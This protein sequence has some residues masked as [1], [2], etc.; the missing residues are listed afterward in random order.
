M[1]FLLIDFGASRVKTALYEHNALQYIKDFPPS[2][3]ICSIDKHFE[4]SPQ[5]LLK[6]FQNIVDEYMALSSKPLKGI[7]ICSEMHG[8]V[9][10]D[11]QGNFVTNYISWQ[12]NRASELIDGVSTL[13][14]LKNACPQF[15]QYTGMK[16][17]NG[18]PVVNVLHLIR[19]KQLPQGNYKMISLPEIFGSTFIHSTLLAGFGIWDIYHNEIYQELKNCYHSFGY[20][21]STNPYTPIVTQTSTYKNIPLYTAIGDNQ[22]AL[23]G[24]HLEKEQLILNLG[25]GSQVA[26]IDKLFPDQKLDQRPYLNNQTLSII[27][28]IPSGRA[29]NCFMGFIDDCIAFGEGTKSSWDILSSL[30]LDDL[31]NAPFD[32]N[33]TVFESAY[34][35]K[36]GGAITRITEKEFTLKYY[37]SSLLASYVR[38]YVTIIQENNLPKNHIVLTGGIAKKLPVIK[39]FLEHLLECSITISNT[40]IDESLLGLQFTADLFKEGS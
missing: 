34:G 25:T 40:S 14:Y 6:L 21:I 4:V 15:R 23:Y 1:S 10:Q 3:P 22:C 26:F 2:A 36:D 20:N 19:D 38:Q 24:I 27:T 18:L 13:E 11:M 29:L 31:L 39:Q 32:I 8:F 16:I 30:T 17:R 12:D 9:L 7:F 5:K 33:L 28:H 37:V 35:F